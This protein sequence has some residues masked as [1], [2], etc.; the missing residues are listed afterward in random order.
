MITTRLRTKLTTGALAIGLLAS[1][2]ASAE[3]W[4]G[5]YRTITSIYPHSG[6]LTFNLSGSTVV[7]A[8][9]CPNRFLLTIGMP[10]YTVVVAAMLSAHAQGKRVMINYEETSVSCDVPVNRFITES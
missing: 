3:T 7:A 9:P 5:D 8:S 10:N 4:T 6:G 2:P 1:L